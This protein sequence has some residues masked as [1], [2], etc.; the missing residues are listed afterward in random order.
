ME[1][2]DR[3]KLKEAFLLWEKQTAGR[4]FNLKGF[5]KAPDEVL[6]EIAME[7][8]IE[9]PYSLSTE[10]KSNFPSTIKTNL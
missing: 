4:S 7:E 8:G 1:A 2:L 10:R 9:I 6:I 3:D 5:A